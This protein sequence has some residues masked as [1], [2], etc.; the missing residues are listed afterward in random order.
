[1]AQSSVQQAARKARLW[2]TTTTA[3]AYAS[4]AAA[5]ASSAGMSRWLVGSSRRT[6][7]GCAHVS[8]ASESRAFWPPESARSGSV[9]APAMPNLPSLAR[10]ASAETPNRAARY[11]A[12][13][14]SRGA[15]ARSASAWSCRANA[16]V[17][18]GPTR[19]PVPASRRR[20]GARSSSPTHGS[21]RPAMVRRS[22]V[23]PLPLSPT[24]A[25]REPGAR[26]ATTLATTGLVLSCA[27]PA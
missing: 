17:T 22:V 20:L 19:S 15:S 18:R 23:L 21:R 4:S 8:A 11:A 7:C 14:A 13:V 1:M 6:T 10:A 16:T 9:A 3:P 27:P 25:T 24:S 5:S 12:V 26:S 2:L